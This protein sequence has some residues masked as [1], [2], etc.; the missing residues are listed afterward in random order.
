MTSILHF[1]R[2]SWTQ[3]ATC[4]RALSWCSVQL[5]HW[6]V[7]SQTLQD[8]NVLLIINSNSWGNGMLVDHA[9]IIKEN[10]HLP[11]WFRLADFFSGEA[12]L[13]VS[14]YLLHTSW[15]GENKGTTFH[16]QLLLCSECLDPLQLFVSTHDTHELLPTIVLLLGDEILVWNTQQ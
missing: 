11:S 16:L 13:Y 6:Y 3:A 8:C 15:G 10:Y 7:S 5:L 9:F 4:G 1:I 12:S 2:N 14:R